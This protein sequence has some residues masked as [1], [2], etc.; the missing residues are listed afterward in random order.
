MGSLSLLST[1]LFTILMRY[2]DVG[3]SSMISICE[4]IAKH[5]ML[6][7]MNSSA[8]IP[9]GSFR[10]YSWMVRVGK[11]WDTVAFLLDF[12]IEPIL[13]LLVVDSFG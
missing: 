3:W 4:S 1:Y 6:K 10:C 8:V 13:I 2:I 12:P 7:L 9:T 5:L 11:Y